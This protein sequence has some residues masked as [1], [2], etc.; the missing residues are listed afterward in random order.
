ML[1]PSSKDGTR[2]SG[3]SV[4]CDGR[5][6]RPTVGTTETAV[7]IVKTVSTVG[8]A[9]RH[10]GS[11]IAAAPTAARLTPRTKPTRGN[12][13]SRNRTEEVATTEPPSQKRK[14]KST[15]T[16]CDCTRP[17]TCTS[18]GAKSRPGCACLLARKKCFGCACF[19]QCQ[20]KRTMLPEAANDRQTGSTLRAYFPSSQAAE[21]DL[22]G[23]LLTQP[24]LPDGNDAPGTATDRT[25]A[26][27]SP[28]AT[29][30]TT[31]PSQ[32]DDDDTDDDDAPT[33]EGAAEPGPQ[34][35][36]IGDSFL[37][38]LPNDHTRVHE[39]AKERLVAK[40]RGATG[41]ASSLGQPT[42]SSTPSTET[43]RMRMTAVTWTEAWRAMRPGSDDGVGS[44]TCQQPTIPCQA[45]E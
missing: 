11:T 24:P 19:R 25:V 22:T 35:E 37:P 18:L 44:S 10:S 20:N 26:A 28:R 4:V 30:T 45:R 32:G 3:D 40:N 21:T 42:S 43:G 41:R 31:A 5:V 2:E 14:T 29:T 8:G 12:A 27:P 34:P 36:D 6:G 39:V 17:S 13:L 1:G 9:K 33:P 23:G 7:P 16:C 38:H 15:T